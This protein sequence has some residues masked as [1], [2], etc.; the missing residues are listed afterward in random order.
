M[1]LTNHSDY[2]FKDYLAI[3]KINNFDIRKTCILAWLKAT[4]KYSAI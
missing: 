2:P 1:N 3:L 4:Y